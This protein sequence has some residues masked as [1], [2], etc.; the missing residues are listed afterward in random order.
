MNIRESI[1]YILG[2]R[3]FRN[4]SVYTGTNL[5]NRAIPFL[6]LPVLTRYLSPFDYGLVATYQVIL[7]VCGVLVRVEMNGAV[8]VNYFKMGRDELRAYL[9]NVIVISCAAF[10]VIS[11]AGIAWMGP[12]SRLLKFP[13]PWILTV[14]AAAL[15]QFLATLVMTLWQVEQ[16]PL[17]YGLFQISQTLVNIGLSLFLIIALGWRWEGR[18]TGI[19]ATSLVFAAVSALLLSVRKDVRFSIEKKHM[20]DA[21]SFGIPL[22]PHALGSLLII[23]ADRIFIN[24][25]VGVEATGMYVVGYQVGMIIEVLAASFNAAWSPFFFE[26]LQQGREESKRKIVVFTYIY[27]AAIVI[28]ALLLSAVAPAFLRFFV[29]K[30]FY[31]SSQYV[32]WI[33]LGFAANGLYYMAANYIFYAKKSHI[34]AWTTLLS[35]GL[36]ILLN[37]V[38]IRKNG[39]VGA[40]QATAITFALTFLTVWLCSMKVC[41]MQWFSLAAGGRAKG[42]QPA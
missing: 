25:M 37:Y 6:L 14:T 2:H 16:K 40:A 22:I 35:A 27:G 15:A 24:S 5:V 4:A 32:F 33:A 31:G 1:K 36:N 7:T 12:L 9:G 34:L 21:L 41:P 11:I 28:L 38:L 3:L 30:N 18:V 13:G 19:F 39:A 23:T 29:G 20:A 26:K 10:L 17:P 8:A 42:A